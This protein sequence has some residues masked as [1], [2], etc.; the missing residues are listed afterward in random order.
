MKLDSLFE[1]S[2]DEICEDYILANALY[3]NLPNNR[4]EEFAEF[5]RKYKGKPKLAQYFLVIHFIS[6]FRHIWTFT[7]AIAI[8]MPQLTRPNQSHHHIQKQPFYDLSLVQAW[9]VV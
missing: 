7:T 6:P 5:Y 2:Q 8:L 3:G 4:R 9:E 1:A